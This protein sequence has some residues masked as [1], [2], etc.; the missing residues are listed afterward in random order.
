[1][2]RICFSFCDKIELDSAVETWGAILFYPEGLLSLYADLMPTYAL[3]VI[4]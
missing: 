2:C 3:L 1:L 4:S